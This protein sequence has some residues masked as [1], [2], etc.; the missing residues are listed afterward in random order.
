MLVI[1][2]TRVQ[3]TRS[4][5]TTL[6]VYILC[7]KQKIGNGSLFFNYITGKQIVGEVVENISTLPDRLYNSL[8][9][10]E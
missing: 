2:Q 3:T 4:G 8:Q 5:K 9:V 7:D 1:I 6:P 10:E